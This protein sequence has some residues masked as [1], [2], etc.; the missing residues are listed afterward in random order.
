MEGILSVG[1]DSLA[2]GFERIGES[3][4]AVSVAISVSILLFRG[5]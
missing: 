3:L 2:E 4:R 5:G 1:E